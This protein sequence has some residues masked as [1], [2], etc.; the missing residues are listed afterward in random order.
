MSTPA[1][2]TQRPLRPVG[3]DERFEAI[4]ITRGIALF[5]V[6]MMN[7]LIDFRVP[8]AQH[9]RQFHTHP[10]PLNNLVDWVFELV[11]AGKAI[12]AFSLL[13][14]VGLAVQADRAEQRKRGALAFLA[15]RLL[16]LLSIGVTHMFLIWNGD[17]L[18]LYAVA[19]LLGLLFVRRSTRVIWIAIGV[20]SVLSS[21][22]V[23]S[24]N[25]V[26]GSGDVA[27]TIA[28]AVR[29]YGS[30]GYL[31]IF[32]FRA[33]EAVHSMI[34]LYL[35]LLPRTLGLFLL[36]VL[37][38][39]R[40]VFQR[41]SEHRSLLRWTAA[42]CGPVGLAATIVMALASTSVISLG[43]FMNP[44]S[45]LTM[46]PLSLAYIAC[47]LM[48]LSRPAY[49]RWLSFFA[50]LGRMAL[51]NYILQ[52]VVLGFVFYGY[53]LGLFGKLGSAAAAPIGFA[54][55]AAQLAFSTAWLRRYRFGPME[56]LWRSL[57]YGQRQP[58]R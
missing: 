43:R 23:R 44:V 22:P 30:G 2:T 24:G 13:F 25:P 26:T 46:V 38:F 29:A 5:G 32:V 37:V 18:S 11:V 35:M 48:L 47:L 4:D 45:S 7:L 17:I 40:G 28:E 57:T 58:M 33:R 20:I 15:R 14:G 52:S 31:E 10:G 55:Y 21:L 51:T 16:V 49:W 54:L 41:P 27:E 9:I 3:G 34:P 50:P 1:E 39:R 36:G 6:L 19:G 53:G 8:L 56:W 12:T 42:V